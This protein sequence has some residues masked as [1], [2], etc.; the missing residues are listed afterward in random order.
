LSTALEREH[1]QVD[2]GLE[3]FLAGLAR[4]QIAP[5]E[6]NAALEGLRRH[7]YLEERILF[8]PMRHTGMAMPVAVMMTEHG[9]IWRTMDALAGLVA[10][11]DTERMRAIC[12]L[13]L[14]Q[15]AVHNSK[16][17]QVIYRAADTGLESDHAAE[18]ADF[19]ETGLMPDCWECLEA[20]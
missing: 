16:E 18:V 19:I 10:G 3:A 13:L 1:Q 14:N 6:L 15:L 11:G 9:E 12:R 8:P 4:G 20:R 7:I 17:E 5:D 2:A